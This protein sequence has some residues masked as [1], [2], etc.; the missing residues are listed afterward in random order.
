ML[1]FHLYFALVSMN[2]QPEE[3]Q[4]CAAHKATQLLVHMNNKVRLAVAA[5]CSLLPG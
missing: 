2:W 1:C 4:I 5:V 3:A